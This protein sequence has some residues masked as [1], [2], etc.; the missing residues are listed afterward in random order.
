[1]VR[2]LGLLV[3]TMLAILSVAT[4][5]QAQDAL[6]RHMRDA[7]RT[8]QAQSIGRLPA[9]RILQLDIVLP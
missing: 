9:N 1:M 2:R 5:S 7:V 3:L 8:G 6:T 4:N